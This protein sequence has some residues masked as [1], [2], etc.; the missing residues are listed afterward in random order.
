MRA[1]ELRPA[2]GENLASF[3]VSA[4]WARGMG[5][6]GAAALR[7]L[8]QRRRMPAVGRFTRAQPHL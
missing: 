8:V 4:R 2:D 3:I 1:H 6:D 7:T 5:P